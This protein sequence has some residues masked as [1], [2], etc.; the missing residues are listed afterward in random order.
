MFSGLYG[1]LRCLEAEGNQV[2]LLFQSSVLVKRAEG[3]YVLTT[4]NVS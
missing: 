3:A 1:M 2:A 4:V